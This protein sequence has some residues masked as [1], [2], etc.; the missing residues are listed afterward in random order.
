MDKYC[1]DKLKRFQ[2]FFNYQ[3]KNPKLLLQALTTPQYGNENNLPHYDILETLGDAVIKLILSLKLY[4]SG[5]EDPGNLTKTKL[6]LEDNQTFLKVAK[7]IELWRFVIASNKQKIEGTSILAD[8]FEAICGAMYIDS[9][10]NLKIVEQKI[11]DK[12]FYDWDAFI[13]QSPHLNKNQLLEYIQDLLRLTPKLK[14]VCQNL[15][16]ENDPRWVAKNL[17]ILDQDLNE[18]IEIPKDLRSEEYKRKIDAEK[19]LSLKI[20]SY[21]KNK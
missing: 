19:D 3:F 12:Y 13:K 16:S 4:N 11:F 14:F 17:K 10:N 2:D 18:I 8:V 9:E 1:E 7:E 21:L 5:E 15:G 20:L 6:Q